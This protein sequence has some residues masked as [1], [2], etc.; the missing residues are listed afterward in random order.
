MHARSFLP[1][2]SSKFVLLLA[3]LLLAVPLSFAKTVVF[4]QPGFP[5]ASSEPLDQ[6]SLT[7]AL[8]GASQETPQF[9]DA[10][11]LAKPDALNDATVLVLPYGSAFPAAQ[12]AAIQS[13]LRNGGNLL[14][15]GGQPFQVPVSVTNGSFQSER[16]QDTYSRALNFRHTYAVPVSADARFAWKAGYE[17]GVAP[18]IRA[19]RFFTVEGHVD[20]LGYMRDRDGLLVAA[21]VIVSDRGAGRIV[22]L[23][24]DPQPGYW[25]SAD[26]QALIRAAAQY[27]AQ[28]PFS[29][30]VETLF[31]AIRPNEPPVLSVHVHDPRKQPAAIP[32]QLKVSLQS[33]GKFHEFVTIHTQLN[34]DSSITIPFR[35]PL[36]AGFYT[37]SATLTERGAFRA[38][39]QNGFWVADEA[40]LATGDALASHGDF[41]TRGGK[42]FFPIGANYF[43]TERNG[44]D[45][46]GP[47]NAAIW[48]H[49]FDEMEHHGVNFVR[50]GVWMRFGRFTEPNAGGGANQRFLRN[51]EAFLLCA[52]RHHIV[53]N[54]T[55]FGMI[56]RAGDNGWGESE[57]QQQPN[58]YLDPGAL[59]QQKAYIGSVVQ[60]F[61]NDPSLTWDLINEPSFS[62][63]RI[64]FHGNV[65]NG[66]P[67]ELAAWRAWLR[68]HY[69]SDLPA[70]AEAWS[71]PAGEL[72]SFD[73]IAL[74]AS[75]DLRAERYGNPRLVRALDYNLF[76]QDAF[77]GWVRGM[78]DTIHAAG[79]NQLI[80]VGQDEGG[81]TDRVLNQFYGGAGVSFTTNH[82]Y[83]QDDALLWDSIAAKR[84][85]LPNITGET[86]YQPVWSPDGSWRYDELTGLGILDRKWALG[87]AAGS[88]GAAM[89]DWDREPDFG[90]L[91]SDGSS[92]VWENRMRDM[93]D[94]AAKAAPHATA[95]QQPDVAIILPQSLQLSV[96][97]NYALEAQK[98]AVR[99]VYAQARSQ[100]YAVGEYQLDLLGSPKLILLPSPYGLTD[101]AWTALLEHVRKGATLLVTGPFDG[102]AHLH[103]TARAQDIGIDYATVP[104]TLRDSEAHF[105]W[106]V[107][108]VTFAGSKTTVL[109]TAQLADNSFWQ[110]K[111]IGSG[112]I[113]FCP[114]PLELSDSLA[115]IGHAY[116]YALK[117]AG[118]KPLYTAENTDAG[119]LIAPTVF[120][121][122]TLYVISSESNQSAVTFTDVRSGA[123]LTGT[124]QPGFAA[125]VLVG[126]D[127]RT[128]AAY[129]WPTAPHE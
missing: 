71:V 121:D 91:R 24:F 62:N 1:L 3:V 47:R 105:P 45:F 101:A 57:G 55:F 29:V 94:F 40:A 37:V 42:P 48:E 113:L 123:K 54:F 86:G 4:W 87:L 126:T 84:P 80:N 30:S 26:G 22:A 103:P 12:F 15:L 7:Q 49:D 65:P 19:K 11:G 128:L 66:D 61:K 53:V 89:W 60:R 70:L 13:Y 97:N 8:A 68:K 33:E 120:P 16:A 5:T 77:S 23:D 122:S 59:V 63:P 99:A 79:S 104:L 43:S 44:W 25:N 96:M 85:G 110:E 2:S 108:T 74:P 118:I 75:A 52:Q 69:D 20:G 46:S 93:G 64:I 38:Y 112:R 56:P 72:G 27:A 125:M 28:P 106:G 117:A 32:G 51:V 82:T 36:P 100:A 124:V 50:T 67:A 35:D 88:S 18:A 34:G 109:S 127:G 14:I 6:Q 111:Q 98:A 81:V 21:P 107:E 58:P 115:A 114:L 92:K 31:G 95:L 10:A 76:A 102:D 83:W 39:Y 129:H 41:L 90:M 17:F 9:I 119:I 73:S 78:V 116:Q